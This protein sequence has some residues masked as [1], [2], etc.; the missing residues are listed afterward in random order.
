MGFARRGGQQDRVFLRTQLL[1]IVTITHRV[2]GHL[3]DAQ[4]KGEVKFGAVI[5]EPGIPHGARS[6]LDQLSDNFVSMPARASQTGKKL[7]EAR[8][9]CVKCVAHN[10]LNILAQRVTAT[11]PFP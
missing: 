10:P 8:L 1:Y 2:S 3:E 7:A 9:V 11:K 4:T 5:G 6:G